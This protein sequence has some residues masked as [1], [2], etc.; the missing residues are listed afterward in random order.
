MKLLVVFEEKTGNLKKKKTSPAFPP[1][2][3]LVSVPNITAVYP[4]IMSLRLPEPAESTGNNKEQQEML[5]LNLHLLLHPHLLSLSLSLTR[6]SMLS[7]YFS[8]SSTSFSSSSFSLTLSSFSS[9]DL[10][11]LHHLCCSFFFSEFLCCPH[12]HL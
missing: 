12:L 4:T 3:S 7:S 2:A 11:L 1:W 10:H 9:S 8:S 5:L 6:V